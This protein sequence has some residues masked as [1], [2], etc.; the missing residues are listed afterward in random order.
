MSDINTNLCIIL[1]AP[2]LGENIGAAARAML[3]FGITDLRLVAPRD[4]WPNER[5]EAMAAGAFDKMPDVQIHNTLAEALTDTHYA[6]A[7]TARPRDMVKPVFTPET[8]IKDIAARAGTGQKV[9]LVFGAERIGLVNDDIALCQGIITVT[10]NPDYPSLNLAQSVALMI[11][12]WHK[13]HNDTPEQSLDM[14]DSF[15]APHETLNGFLERLEEELETSNFFRSEDLKPTMVR[16]V[17][18]I[19]T[20]ADLSDQEVRTLHGMLSALIGK[21]K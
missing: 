12:E 9:A 6:L 17:Q 13:A 11:Y 3:N 16:N 7:M 4:G 14:G 2:Q 20:R 15:P 8:G 5:A 18:N 19:F 1:V 10:T 21:K